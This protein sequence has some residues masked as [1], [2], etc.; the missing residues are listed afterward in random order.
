GETTK[1][2][3]PDTGEPDPTL[4]GVVPAELVDDYFAPSEFPFWVPPPPATSPDG[5]LLARALLGAGGLPQHNR[6]RESAHR[7]VEVLHAA[8]GRLHH[9]LIGHTADLVGIAFS[10]DG[11]RIATASLD[12]TIK[13]WDAATG[14]DVFT[15]RGHTAGLLALAFSPDGRR[16]VS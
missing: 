16:I 1:G 13:L 2:W 10:P 15:I 8:T 5:R 9:T 11:R 6:S 3:D 4:T 12:R 14:R 7:A